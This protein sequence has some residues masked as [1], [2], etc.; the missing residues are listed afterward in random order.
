MG[1]SNLYQEEY[2]DLGGYIW[3]LD[4]E[5]FWGLKDFGQ[6]GM[7]YYKKDIGGIFGS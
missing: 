4:M 7:T 1:V 5:D 2:K 6:M 3:I